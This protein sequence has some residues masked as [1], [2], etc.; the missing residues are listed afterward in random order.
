MALSPLAAR[1]RELRFR[2]AKV[3]STFA[4]NALACG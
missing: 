2:T 4:E 1:V 3:V